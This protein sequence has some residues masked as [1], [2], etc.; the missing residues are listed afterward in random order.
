MRQKWKHTLRPLAVAKAKATTRGNDFK[1]QNRYQR[2]AFTGQ[3]THV[4]KSTKH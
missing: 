1:I 3:G 4:V 2:A